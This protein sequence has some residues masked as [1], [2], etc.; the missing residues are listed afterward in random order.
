MNVVVDEARQNAAAFQVDRLGLWAGRRHHILSASYGGEFPICNRDRLGLRAGAIER[1]EL[2][3]M[4]NEIW[5]VLIVSLLD[6]E[7]ERSALYGQT[8]GPYGTLCGYAWVALH[9]GRPRFG[10][11]R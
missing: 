9:P 5:S 10:L 1:R 6:R 11:I 2:T 7:A 3:V 4:Q 8:S